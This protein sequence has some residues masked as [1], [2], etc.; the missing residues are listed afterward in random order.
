MLL[1]LI[2]DTGSCG[3][4]VFPLTLQVFSYRSDVKCSSFYSKKVK[5]GQN[6]K[7]SKKKQE[8]NKKW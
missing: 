5:E 2:N 3:P 1:I 6:D 8:Q 7:F 4:L